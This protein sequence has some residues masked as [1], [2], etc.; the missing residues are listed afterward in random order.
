MKL[1]FLLYLEDDDAVVLDMLEHVGVESWSRISLDGHAPGHA[2]WYGAVAPF[3]S[4][5]IFSILPA[6]QAERLIETV[7]AC[8]RCQDP[9]HPVHAIQVDVERAVESGSAGRAL[10]PKSV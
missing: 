1:V 10:E 9:A 8:T 2:G 3:R 5:M 7:R 6:N 4:R